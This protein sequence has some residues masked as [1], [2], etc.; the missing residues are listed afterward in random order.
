[1]QSLKSS[2]LHPHFAAWWERFCAYRDKQR[3]PHAL[4][5]LGP[6]HAGVV[7]FGYRMAAGLLCSNESKPCGNCKPCRLLQAR[8][9][10]DLYHLQPEKAGGIIKIDQIRELQAVAFNTPQLGSKRFIIIHPAEKMNIAAANALLKL[11]EEPPECIIFLLIAEQI[12]TVPPTILSRCQHWHFT[13]VN[14][15]NVDYLTLGESYTDETNRGKIF[16]AHTLILQDLLDLV[17]KKIHVCALATKWSTYELNDLLWLIYLISAQMLQYQL[18]E[19]RY[20]NNWT[21]QLLELSKKFMPLQ[22]FHQLDEL[23]KI[24][25]KLNQNSNVNQTLV[26]ENLLVEYCK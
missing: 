4:L 16:N 21:L 6:Q 24:M 13:D 15:L 20:E 22:L 19:K 25:R 1:M 2:D 26:L 14:A 23:N 9:H 5:L 8:E 11:L 17:D 3:F 18:L 10:P 12:S 7:D